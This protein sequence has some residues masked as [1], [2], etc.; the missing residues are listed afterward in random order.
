MDLSG[1]VPVAVPMEPTSSMRISIPRETHIMYW[2]GLHPTPYP[3]F[4]KSESD[5]SR[6]LV[7]FQRQLLHQTELAVYVDDEQIPLLDDV[8]GQYGIEYWTL[9]EPLSEGSHTLTISISY[10][11]ATGDSAETDKTYL[12]AGA[13]PPTYSLP[14]KTMI[15]WSDRSENSIK[16]EL[17]VT[18]DSPTVSNKTLDPL[19]ERKDVYQPREYEELEPSR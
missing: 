5:T 8:R 3:P 4:N 17:I 18:N 11:E 12:P 13:P 1:V 2:C 6:E 16:S 9:K 14:S 15:P 10:N 19:W 7:E